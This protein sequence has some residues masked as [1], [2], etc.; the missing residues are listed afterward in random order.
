MNNIFRK[1]FLVAILLSTSS[2]GLAGWT[3]YYHMK[4]PAKYSDHMDFNV[5]NSAKIKINNN[6]LSISLPKECSGFFFAGLITPVTPPIPVLNFRN[7]SFFDNPCNNFTI[8]TRIVDAEISLKTSNTLYKPNSI[9]KPSNK[10]QYTFPIKAKNIDSG[11]I[12]IEK[13]GEKVEVPFE[14]KYFKFWH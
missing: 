12:I 6:E 8:Y 3:G 4:E 7:I 1:S 14:Y 5:P 11:S 10:L 9:Y 2:C 13:D